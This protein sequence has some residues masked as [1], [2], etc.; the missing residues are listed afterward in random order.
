MPTGGKLRGLHLRNVKNRKREEKKVV[1]AQQMRDQTT[2]R[3][4]TPPYT[5]HRR[6]HGNAEPRCESVDYVAHEQAAT[7]S[8][9]EWMQREY[10]MRKH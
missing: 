2:A 7:V 5:A 10:E 1:Q 9:Q 6:D 8:S 4:R 3:F